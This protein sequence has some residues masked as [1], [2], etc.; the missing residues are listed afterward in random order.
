MN[1]FNGPP[2]KFARSNKLHSNFVNCVR[3]S[4]DG[5][6]MCQVGSDMKGFVIDSAS[7]DTLGELKGH[8]GTI[9]A[10]AWSSG[11]L[12]AQ[13]LRGAAARAVTPPARARPADGGRI[14]TASADKTVIVWDASS[15]AALG[16]YT[17]ADKPTPED[18]QVGVVWVPGSE[19]IIA[20]SLRGDL[21]HLDATTPGKI[22]A[23]V[24]APPR[25]TACP[26]VHPTVAPTPALSPSL[27]RAQGHNKAITAL[28]VA[29]G[30]DA[31]VSASYDAQVTRF[32]LASGEG[33]GVQGKG[34][35]NGVVNPPPAPLPALP[36][37]APRGAARRR[38]NPHGL[39]QVDVAIAG[40]TVVSVALD[41]TLRATA[42]GTM[43]LLGGPVPLGGQP[44]AL[45]LSADARLAVVATNK[46]LVVLRPA[47]GGG[48]TVAAQTPAAFGAAGVAIAPGGAEVAVAGDDKGVHIYALAVPRAAPATPAA[49]HPPRVR[50]TRACGASQGDVL[51]PG[52]ILTGHL[53]AVTRVA[54]APARCAPL[55]VA[56]T[57]GRPRLG[58]LTLHGRGA[59][60]GIRRAGACWRQATRAR[61]CLSGTRLPRASRSRALRTTRRVPRGGWVAACR[62]FQR[63]LFVDSGVFC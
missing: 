40:D 3:Y 50:L 18:M 57:R 52:E 21:H 25:P 20:L 19:R 32:S 14:V 7:G 29:P 48:F 54:W 63:W 43:E 53:A 24:K 31:V 13:P 27:P 62:F 55:P 37:P 30:G 38:S 28:A 2:F 1:V 5:A 26:T 60:A 39:P 45:A 8:K 16:T 61:S 47:P 15:C 10:C 23:L 9:Y 4:P 41:D 34:H 12:R 36:F 11:A 6:R 56:R 17:F 59:V 35:T 33:R 46:A 58:V 42:L 49:A 51:T 22:T 44:S